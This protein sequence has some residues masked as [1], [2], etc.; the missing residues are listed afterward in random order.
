MALLVLARAQ[1]SGVAL[2]STVL[3]PEYV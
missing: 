3:A 1:S 2:T